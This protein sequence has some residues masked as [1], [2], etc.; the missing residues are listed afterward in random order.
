M[1]Q[2]LA[3]LLFLLGL[4]LYWRQR[5]LGKYLSELAD[6]LEEGKTYLLERNSGFV[7]SSNFERLVRAC[8]SLVSTSMKANRAQH[9]YLRQIEATLGNIREA[10]FI[11][12]ADNYVLLANDIVRQF[13]GKEQPL[14]GRRLETIVPSAAFL[15]YVRAI[16]LGER[17]PSE[18]IELRRG[19]ES[20][21]FEVSGARLPNQE[22]ERQPLTLFVLHDITRRKRLENMRT[23]F[24]ANVSHELRT[25]VTIIK[26]FAETLVEDHHIL[27]VEDRDRFLIKIQ[28]N[29]A[30][31]HALLEDLLTLSR[32]EAAVDPL[33]LNMEPLGQLAT[34]IGEN[35]KGRLSTA[36]RLSIEVE[37]GDSTVPVDTIRITQVLENLLENAVRHARGATELLIR[38]T[39]LDGSVR[40]LV[41]DNGCGIP[42]EDLPHI[43]ERFYR[44]E[45]GR[46]RETGGTGLGLSIVKHIIIQHGGLIVA[47]SE[48][49]KGSKI[50][51]VLPSTAGKRLVETSSI[52][53]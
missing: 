26:G 50:G 12:D 22:E 18:E 45:K 28:K 20:F 48:A 42:P 39:P 15:D 13:L 47:E 14:L 1:Y 6:A 27:S 8:N 30:R 17:R 38:V 11:V 31:L 53:G 24:V 35:F 25:P 36:Q 16:K 43:F 3:L 21:W 34:E 51:F 29:V 5:A 44:V 10:I 46:S 2:I 49:G 52:T 7:Q 40:C 19:R 32:L 41:E 37:Q 33:K 4:A 9:D 23:E